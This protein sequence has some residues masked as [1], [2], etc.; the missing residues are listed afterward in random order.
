M[1]VV[2]RIKLKASSREEAEKKM[3]RKAKKNLFVVCNPGYKRGPYRSDDVR[4]PGL[5]TCEV[6]YKK[7]ERR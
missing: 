4:V 2:D 3:L 5:W 6:N 7:V 1:V